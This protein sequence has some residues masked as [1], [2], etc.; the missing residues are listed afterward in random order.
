[1]IL[2]DIE[3]RDIFDSAAGN[4][5]VP[6]LVPPNNVSALSIFQCPSSPGD[7]APA[8]IAYAAN[9]GSENMAV[10]APA[11]ELGPA[12][13]SALGSKGL[14]VFFDRTP[15]AGQQRSIGL[16]FIGSGDGT[17]NTLLFA[18]R[19]GGA[20]PA[21]A[22]W[23]ANQAAGFDW[24]MGSEIADFATPGFVLA[25]TASSGKVINAND[26][27]FTIVMAGGVSSRSVDP[28]TAFPSSNHPGGVN[29][30]F[31]DGHNQFLRD[32]IAPSVY[33]QLMTS[34]M[35]VA[36]AAYSFLPVLREQDYK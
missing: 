13:P 23:T 30:V 9:C 28:R 10:P 14:G 32:T 25:G 33:S 34:R 19:C 36:S 18:E 8:A 22:R 21:Q 7:A 2:P 26:N 17:S 6:G 12:D 1:M 29:V 27:T 24:R 4:T 5:A 31:C 15:L 20:V 3:R 11:S 16:D 35:K